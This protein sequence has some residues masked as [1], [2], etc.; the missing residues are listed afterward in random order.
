MVIAD[1]TYTED[2]TKGRFFVKHFNKNGTCLLCSFEVVYNFI[3]ECVERIVVIT[4]HKNTILSDIVMRFL[5]MHDWENGLHEGI[6]IGVDPERGLNNIR[7]KN[8]VE[9]LQNFFY[10]YF[11][12]MKSLAQILY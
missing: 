11:Q 4:C 3:T 9:S 7:I 8:N 12:E 2:N 10:F 5:M 1:I 6:E